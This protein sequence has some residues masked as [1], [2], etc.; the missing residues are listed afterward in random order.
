MVE[1]VSLGLDV[2]LVESEQVM[3]SKSEVSWFFAWSSC[4]IGV[5]I[6]IWE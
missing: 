1:T 2:R 3:V 5:M 4:S 6:E